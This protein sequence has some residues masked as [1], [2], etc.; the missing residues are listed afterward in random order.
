MAAFTTFQDV[1]TLSSLKPGAD[2]GGRTG[3]YV[4]LKNA[5]FATVV[6]YVTQGNAATVALDVLQASAVAGTGA[7]AL[8]VNVPIETCLDA[9]TSSVGARQTDAKAFTTDAATKTKIVKF[10]IDPAQLDSANGFDCIACRTG[11]S[12]AANITSAVIQVTPR[13]TGIAANRPNYLVD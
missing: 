9:D 7:K 12:N 5:M 3:T 13:Y 2:A 1:E 10:L 6:F 11:A 8:S 4:S